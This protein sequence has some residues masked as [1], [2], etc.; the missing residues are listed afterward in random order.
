[1]LRAPAFLMSTPYM[2]MKASA[3][4]WPPLVVTG[5]LNELVT[6]S[7]DIPLS[8]RMPLVFLFCFTVIL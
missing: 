5:L 6:T 7:T 2:R 3:T 8:R 1:M 4:H